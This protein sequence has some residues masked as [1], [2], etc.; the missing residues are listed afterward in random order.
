MYITTRSIYM[1]KDLTAEEARRTISP[2]SDLFARWLFSAPNHENLTKSFI[3]AVLDM[4]VSD[5]SGH[6]YDVEIQ[7]TTNEV[8]WKRLTYYNNAMYNSQLKSS[9]QYDQLGSTTVIALLREHI[10]S[11]DRK[12]QPEDKLHHCSLVVHEDDHDGLFY[13]NGD[14]E[15]FHIIELDRF[16]LNAD[17]LY[18]V[19][20]S[21]KRKLAP[22][23]FRWLRFFTQ[24][25]KEDFMEKYRE[26]DVAVKEAKADYEQF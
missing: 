18:T 22:S 2:T 13:P 10:Y 6:Q 5:Q 21:E 7:T 19:S 9:R 8:F 11:M 4:K 14:P 16:A 15:K 1:K 24:G 20:G 25:A 12:V 3:N 17:A 26:T 23:L